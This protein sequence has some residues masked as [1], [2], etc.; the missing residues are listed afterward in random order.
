V[1]RDPRTWEKAAADLLVRLLGDE[2]WEAVAAPLLEH[3]ALD[4]A[5]VTVFGAYDS[6]KSTLLKRLLIE[7]GETIP[8]WLTISARRETFEAQSVDLS[9][10]R[11]RDTPGLAGGK[12]EHDVIAHEALALSDAVLLVLPPQLLTGERET[13]VALF[14]GNR[15]GSGVELQLPADAVYIAVARMDEAGT[16]STEN[17]PGY[18]DL[19]RRKL[20]ELRG[21]LE[22]EGVAFDERRVFFV[23]ADPYQQV[24]N[25]SNVRPEEY[26]EFRAWDGVAWRGSENVSPLSAITYRSFG[27]ELAS[28]T[29]P[30]CSPRASPM[31]VRAARSSRRRPPTGTCQH[32]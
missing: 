14:R 17:P 13:I 27:R 15:S 21:Q 19:C 28:G 11:L 26:D 6:G 8:G 23:S 22:R 29:S 25:R 12:A 24:G 1:S 18:E 20:V 16:D 7:E 4:R 5:V 10:A 30:P 9:W 32:E 3:D 2:G 31:K